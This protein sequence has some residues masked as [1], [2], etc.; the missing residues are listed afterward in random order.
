[1]SMVSLSART[2]TQIKFHHE[3]SIRSGD[4]SHEERYRQDPDAIQLPEERHR[5]GMLGLST[6]FSQTM[7]GGFE[8][9]FSRYNLIESYQ[10]DSIPAQAQG[11]YVLFICD[12]GEALV[13]IGDNQYE[14]HEGDSLAR[15][16]VD[17]C[18]IS[19][20]HPVSKNNLAPILKSIAL[21]VLSIGK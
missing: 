10:R 14:L 3:R 4:I 9:V 8:S 11:M 19:P 13:E 17:V 7:G 18:W 5:L 12:R 1:M 2:P 16:A 21:G 20:L 15:H 6:G